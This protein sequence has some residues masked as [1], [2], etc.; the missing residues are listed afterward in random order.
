MLRVALAETGP[1]PRQP[2]P[3]C[4]ESAKPDGTPSTTP[5]QS[6]ASLTCSCLGLP[7]QA[8]VFEAFL[9]PGTL[10]PASFPGPW[11]PGPA[12]HL[13]PSLPFPTGHLLITSIPEKTPH[14]HHHVLGETAVLAYNPS[15]PISRGTPKVHL[16]PQSQDRQPRPHSVLAV[17]FGPCKVGT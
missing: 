4:R 3:P 5:L 6:A 2:R 8:R 7:K 11:K 16:W 9:T 10:P 14:H 12:C 17:P 1:P 15:S 13:L